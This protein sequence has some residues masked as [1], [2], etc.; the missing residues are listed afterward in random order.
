MA[1]EGPLR[2]PAAS[3]RAEEYIQYLSEASD[4]LDRARR[5]ASYGARLNLEERFALLGAL[6]ARVDLLSP[7]PLTA[8]DV[9]EEPFWRHWMDPSVGRPR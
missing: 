3:P 9:R 4:D 8:E 5:V 1:S 7:A 2:S 6:N